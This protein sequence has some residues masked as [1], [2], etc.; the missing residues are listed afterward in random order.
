MKKG[1]S[2]FLVGSLVVIGAIAYLVYTGIKETSVYYFSVSEAVAIAKKGEDFRMEGKVLNGSVKL[3]PDSLGASFVIAD[4]K[5]QMP[6]VF[7]GALPDMFK[8][9]VDVVVQGKL[10]NDGVFK[11]HTLLTSCPSKYEAAEEGKKI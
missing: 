8:D 4:S 5:E 3:N 11:A 7:K 6:I 2:K 10:D 1:Q 9:D